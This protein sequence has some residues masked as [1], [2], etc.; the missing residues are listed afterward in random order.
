MAEK[1][2]EKEQAAHAA[3]VKGLIGEQRVSLAAQGIDLGTGSAAALTEQSY[4][5]GAEDQMTIRNNAWREAWGL[6]MQSQQYT[7]AGNMALTGGRNAAGNTLLTGFAQA[8]SY[9]IQAGRSSSG[10]TSSLR[11]QEYS[12]AGASYKDHSTT[13]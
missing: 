1:R 8:A 11:P 10:R 13:V 12:S 2:G 6:K 3:R 4:R 7:A 9:G 5:L